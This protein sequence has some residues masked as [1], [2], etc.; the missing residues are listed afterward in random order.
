M[1]ETIKT[2]KPSVF[3][4]LDLARR[5]RHAESGLA[6]QFLLVNQTHEIA[7]YL[8]AALWV[9]DEGVVM[10]SGVTEVEKHAP[11]ILW[12][13]Q[14]GKYL[15]ETQNKTTPVEPSMLSTNDVDEWESNL[16]PEALWLPILTHQKK[17]GLLVCRE[18]VWA[19]QEI[20]LL[21]EW[22]DTWGHAWN[23]MHVQSVP[24]E[25]YQMGQSLRAWMSLSDGGRDEGFFSSLWRNKRRRFFI[26][27]FAVLFVPVRL[28]VL[29]PAEIVSSKP[30][31]IRVPIE[32][33]VDEFFVRPNQKVIEGQALLKLDLTSLKSRLQI[34]QQETQVASTEY[35]QSTL[36]SLSDPKSRTQLATQE[37]KTSG[38][39]L[40]TEYIKDLLE[41]AQ[42]KSPR[43]G[44]AIF[45]DP[46]E[47]VGK[48]VAA[49]ERVMIIA[50]EDEIEIEAWLSVNNAIELPRD[51]RV[52]F[53]LNTSPLSPIEGTVKSIGYEAVQRP[54]STY[55]YRLRADV[56]SKNLNQRIGLK[57]TAKVSGR[58]VPLAYWVL[59]RPLA[60]ARQFL[61][62]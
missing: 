1:E 2:P 10:Q 25:M 15:S 5:A 34:A 58:Y 48:P 61:G 12:L 18:E 3:L 42:I 47:W 51:A 53:Y 41:K 4:L 43:D 49:G 60:I 13:S 55:A 9:E 37:G 14:L 57:G 20:K 36:Q 16:P 22:I 28:T 46:S 24:G 29:A 6:L 56:T 31:V 39:R 54:D 11:F 52:T 30:A 62:L 26:L 19:E 45:D 44:I 40:E 59:R 38:K 7:P 35:R 23:K 50:N 27:A 21:H 32:G 33:V 8:I 17:A